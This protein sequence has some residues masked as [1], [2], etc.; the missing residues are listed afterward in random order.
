MKWQ[1]SALLVILLPATACH[2]NRPVAAAPPPLNIPSA[3][4]LPAALVDGEAAF[5]NGE[6]ARAARAYDTYLQSKPQMSEPDRIL[7]RFG[8]SQSMSG[9]AALESASSGTFNQLIRDYP[10]SVFIAP[11]RMI[12]SLRSDI[13]RLQADQKTR[14][15]KIKQLNDELDRLKKIDLDRSRTR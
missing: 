9:V 7:F 3:P 13:A 1:H 14:D 2:R 4:A 15:D 11:A 8:V 10:K 5:A 12:L 6:Y